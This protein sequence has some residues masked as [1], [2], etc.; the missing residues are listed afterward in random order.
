MLLIHT[1]TLEISIMIMASTMVPFPCKRNQLKF[2]S[3]QF[4]IIILVSLLRIT[5]LEIFILIKANPVTLFL[6]M[7]NSSRLSFQHLVLIIPPLL[8]YYV[9]QHGKY[10][11]WSRQ[12]WWYYLYVWE[13]IQN[14]LFNIWLLSSHYSNNIRNSL[15]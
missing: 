13:I 5:T 8:Q 2:K 1:L 4:M 12:V 15:Q 3:L 10:L 7:R 9:S 6:Y 11:V 14:W